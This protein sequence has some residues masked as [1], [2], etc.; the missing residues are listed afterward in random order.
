[1]FQTHLSFHQYNFPKKQPIRRFYFF[2]L[3][4]FVV[5]PNQPPFLSQNCYDCRF[6]EIDNRRLASHYLEAIK[7]GEKSHQILALFGGKAPHQHSFFHGGGA[8]QHQQQIK[9][10]KRL[11]LYAI[12]RIS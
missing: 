8:L 9:L 6:D 12:F 2:G 7:A 4:D 3:P 11:H 5:M 10:T 1:M